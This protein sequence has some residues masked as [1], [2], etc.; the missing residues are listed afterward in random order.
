MMQRKKLR[1][2]AA[3]VIRGEDPVLKLLDL[4][5]KLFFRSMCKQYMMKP[6]PNF[7]AAMKTG[8]SKNPSETLRDDALMQNQ[9]WR[10][11]FIDSAKRE[12]SRQGFSYF[13]GS[14]AAA[15]RLAGKVLELMWTVHGTNVIEPLMVQICEKLMQQ[16]S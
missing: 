4:R 13:S 6:S 5:V 15:S 12:A 2:H 1:N 8:R 7:P 3:A 11:E 9:I 14:L 10:D 16:T